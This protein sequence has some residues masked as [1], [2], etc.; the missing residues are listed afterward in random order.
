LQDRQKQAMLENAKLK[1]EVALQ[2]VGI[3]NLTARLIKQQIAYDKCEKV[4][5]KYEQKSNF[6]RE[7][8]ADTT[9][10]KN[11]LAKKRE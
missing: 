4:L 2:G 1:D 6:L 5:R 10:V 8:L 11:D 3:S 9:R 7:Q